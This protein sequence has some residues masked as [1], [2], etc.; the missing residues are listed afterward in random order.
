M[1]YI[2]GFFIIAIVVSLFDCSGDDRVA[3]H[4]AELE[5]QSHMTAEDRASEQCAERVR[6]AHLGS[7]AAFSSFMASC[8]EGR[9]QEG[10]PLVT[11]DQ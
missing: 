6:K 10:K 5:R 7:G 8:F 4:A 3:K 9:H 2:V 1:Q 11:W